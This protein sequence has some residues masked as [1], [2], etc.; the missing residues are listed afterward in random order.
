MKILVITGQTATGKTKLALELAQ[1]HDG[2]LVNFDSRQ[3]YKH[4]DIV[5]G[6][7]VDKLQGTPVWLY[8]IVDPKNP[9][10]AHDYEKQALPV[11]KEI[12]SRGKTPILVGGTYFYLKYLLYMKEGAESQTDWDLRTEL[13]KKT[14]NEL[15]HMLIELNKDTFEHMNDSDKLNPHRLSRKIELIKQGV[16]LDNF[17]TDIILGNKLGID[18][19]KV[20]ITGLYYEDR[21]K[22]RAIIQSRVEERI[23]DGAV[24]EVKSL[25]KKGYSP[26][27]PGLN[28]IG[29]KQILDFLRGAITQDQMISDWAHKEVQ[30]AKRQYTFM[31]KDPNVKWKLMA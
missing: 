28:T 20:E 10:S 30:Y 27:D 9:F 7:D 29:Y 12:I 11:L 8:D 23:E 25:L 3:I 4:L 26:K 14:V 22:L 5:T 24:E 15:Q 2:E 6:K 18:N 21:E 1:K 16:E 19:L 13:N 17:S 31:K